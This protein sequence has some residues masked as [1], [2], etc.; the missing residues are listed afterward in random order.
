MPGPI[1]GSPASTFWYASTDRTGSRFLEFVLCKQDLSNRIG[2]VVFQRHQKEG[3]EG[4]DGARMPMMAM[5]PCQRM[6]ASHSHSAMD[7][8]VR[9]NRD[10]T[11]RKIKRV[12][13]REAAL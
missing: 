3:G 11:E 9:R 8:N 13:E 1:L 12:N 7:I 6:L 5:E 2:D 4:M 10:G